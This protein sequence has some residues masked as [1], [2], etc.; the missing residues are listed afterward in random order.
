MKKICKSREDG[1][2]EGLRLASHP[3]RRA[4]GHMENWMNLISKTFGYNMKMA[5]RI[6]RE[7]VG[8]ES[9]TFEPDQCFTDGEGDQSRRPMPRQTSQVLSLKRRKPKVLPEPR[10][11]QQRLPPIRGSPALRTTGGGGPFQDRGRV[12]LRFIGVVTKLD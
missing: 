7:G 10:Q 2:F 4:L 3:P 12:A 11:F 9:D 8:N 6:Q 5:D 1:S